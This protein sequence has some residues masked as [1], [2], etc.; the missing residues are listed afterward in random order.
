MRWAE[1]V[2]PTFLLPHLILEEN[3]TERCAEDARCADLKLFA[4]IDASVQV[5]LEIP[6]AKLIEETPAGDLWEDAALV[7]C[8]V[9]LYNSKFLRVPD[10][11]K[12][13]LGL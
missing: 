12:V 11:F 13:A 7:D 4:Q 10:E 1:G 9:Y 6:L 8:L 5:D 2:P 3:A